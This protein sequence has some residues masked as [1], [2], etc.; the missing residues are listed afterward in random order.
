MKRIFYI[1]CLTIIATV[2][3]VAC[4]N[5]QDVILPYGTYTLEA[6]EDIIKPTIELGEDGK[7]T[8]VFSALSS[9]VGY[10]AY[11][12]KDN[13]LE[14]KTDDQQ[15]TYIFDIVNKTLVFDT[16]SSSQITGIATISNG[17]IFK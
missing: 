8:F 5:S 10:G 1:A 9:Y 3:L 4:S 13:H 7:F 16:D 15:Y 2:M 12:I 11:E 6:S 14:L 17:A